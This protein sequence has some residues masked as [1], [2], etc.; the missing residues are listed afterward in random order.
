MIKL[1]NIPHF[2]KEERESKGQRDPEVEFVSFP[3]SLPKS[4]TLETYT[5]VTPRVLWPLL[6]AECVGE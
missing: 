5:S 1:T 2:K 4:S 6:A 3:R